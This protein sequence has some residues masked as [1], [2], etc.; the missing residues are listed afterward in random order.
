MAN[1]PVPMPVILKTA[2]ADEYAVHCIVWDCTWHTT[3]EDLQNARLVRLVHWTLHDVKA[4]TR[5]DPEGET[6][7]A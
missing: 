4:P 7:D 5:E 2:V 3:A 1:S 6:W